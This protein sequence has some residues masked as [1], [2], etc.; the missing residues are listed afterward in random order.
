MPA[1]KEKS[2]RNIAIYYLVL[3]VIGAFLSLMYVYPPDF[4]I[5][6][7]ICIILMCVP[8]LIYNKKWATV[9]LSI[10]STLTT[11]ALL[12]FDL[13]VLIIMFTPVFSQKPDVSGLIIT[14][15]ITLIAL[16]SGYV[17]FNLYI[18]LLKKKETE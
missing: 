13:F 14:G 9:L 4:G 18:L 6:A 5:F 2:I 7:L 12:F 11:L 3:G 15:I 17:C 1:S 10:C 16:L 8:R